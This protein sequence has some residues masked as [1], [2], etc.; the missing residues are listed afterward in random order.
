MEMAL[1]CDMM[2]RKKEKQRLQ[3]VKMTRDDGGKLQRGRPQET[4]PRRAAEGGRDGDEQPRR[5][6]VRTASRRA[7]MGAAGADGR[8][9][10]RATAHADGCATGAA[11]TRDGQQTGTAMRREREN[12]IV[13]G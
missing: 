10:G 11:T 5:R 1:G 8:G 13:G 4:R 3:T 9:T 12:G 2:K 7:G 6:G